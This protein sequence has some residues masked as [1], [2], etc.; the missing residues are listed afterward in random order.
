LKLSDLRNHPISVATL[1]KLDVAGSSQ[2]EQEDGV[3][4]DGFDQA[5]TIG[6]LRLIRPGAPKVREAA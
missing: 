4:S 1:P 2:L 6:R 5:H 3:L